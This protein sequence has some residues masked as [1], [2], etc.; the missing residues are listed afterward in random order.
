MTPTR[1]GLTRQQA[2]G[3]E[4]VRGGIAVTAGGTKKIG[5]RGRKPL[6]SGQHRTSR[7]GKMVIIVGHSR[8]GLGGRL[9]EPTIHKW[10]RGRC[11]PPRDQR[12]ALQHLLWRRRQRVV[13]RHL[14]KVTQHGSR[15]QRI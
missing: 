14:R 12:R 8:H 2:R 4:E 11:N 13:N 6:Q 7:L 10:R 15:R 9:Y 3:K 5:V 1:M